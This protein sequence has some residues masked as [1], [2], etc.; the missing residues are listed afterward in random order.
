[1]ESFEG[2]NT[3]VLGVS[4][5]SMSTLKKFAEKHEIAFPLISDGDKTLKT[6]YSGKRIN[7]LIDKEGTIRLIQKG[8]PANDYFLEKIKA[9]ER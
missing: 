7:Y 2:L 3:Q 5:D 4:S 9:L 8:I 1:M 6:L